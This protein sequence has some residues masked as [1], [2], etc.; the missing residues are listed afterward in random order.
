MSSNI[1]TALTESQWFTSIMSSLAAFGV[2]IITWVGTRHPGLAFAKYIARAM[3]ARDQSDVELENSLFLQTA[4]GLGLKKFARSQCQ[5]EPFPAQTQIARFTLTSSSGAP[6]TSAAAGDVTV[7]QAGGSL[8]WVNVEP[9][10]LPPAGKIVVL[11][12][13]RSAG[14]EYNISANAQLELRTTI[15]GAGVDNRPVGQAT[16]IGSGA[17]GLLLFAARA[18][19]QFQIVNAGPSMPLGVTENTMTGI[20][21][22]T[23]AT[24]GGGVIT[25]TADDVRD[26][27]S[28]V[29]ELLV[30]AKNATI[31][32]GLIVAV[33]LTDLAW[34]GSYIE[35]P[36]AAEESE[37]SIKARCLTRFMGL[38]GWA[39]DGAPPAP[40][41]TDEGLEYWARQP[42]AGR[43]TSPVAGVRILSNYYMGS[44]SGNDITAVIWGL[45]GALSSDD[46]TAVDGNFYNGRKFSLGADLHTVTVTNVP[47]V[48]T[49]TVDVYIDY[50][51]T[52]AEVK[53]LIDARIAAYQQNPRAVFPGVT[54]RREVLS[55]KIAD[56]LPDQALSNIN[57]TLPAD[58]TYTFL[59]YPVLDTSGLTVNF[60]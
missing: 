24:D 43:T 27:L 21:T 9:F 18:G 22:V 38:G 23:P 59:Q 35:T 10:D 51:L 41:A 56:A 14:P 44:P 49:G 54:L 60:I 32:T 25:S 3:A 57:L 36:G 48:L 42:P 20:I 34:N 46:V 6:M 2:P 8:E 30:Y 28:A 40:A 26:A 1:I 58:T 50:G 53:A 45:L 19:V 33:G 17:A 55:A 47:V 37:D 15:V 7:G 5:L 52:T 31:G 4:T 11:F 39:G 13:A 12:A 16:A 29:P